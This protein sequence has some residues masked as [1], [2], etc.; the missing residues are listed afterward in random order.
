VDD[1]HLD[2]DAKRLEALGLGLDAR[3][4]VEEREPGRGAGADELR[5]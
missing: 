5:G 3:G 2:V 4:L 1:D